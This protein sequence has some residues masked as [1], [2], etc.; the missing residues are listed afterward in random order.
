MWRPIQSKIP[1]FGFEG[2]HPSIDARM[3]RTEVRPLLNEACMLFMVALIA[4]ASSPSLSQ[5]TIP[6]TYVDNRIV[7]QCTIDGR[8]PF[9]MIVD[10]GSP[11]IVVTPEVAAKL[12]VDVREA[13][14][15]LGTGNTNA[16]LESTTIPRLTIGTL[17]FKNMPSDV[18]DL[19]EIR[20][21]LHFPRLDGVIGYPVLRKF[22]T[23]V[24]VDNQTITFARAA[25]P[26][27]PNATTTDFSGVQPEIE[28]VI[29]GI[30]GKVIVDTG[31]RSS[32]TLFGPFAR[33]YGFFGRY[34]SRKNIITG[35]GLG[36]PVYGDV[37]T[38]PSID[39]F[40]AHLT[41][42]VTRA[43]RQTGG[44]FAT[45][46]DSASIG[47]GI[48]KRFNIVYDYPNSTIIAWPSKHFA[49]PD[50]FVPPGSRGARSD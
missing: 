39:A 2:R 1:R 46:A 8:G 32:L 15:V 33:H 19:T 34:P 47:T 7:V 12:S 23:Y 25:P 40:G 24:D 41:N 45:D 5:T 28:A 18:L 9:A 27:P 26:V 17:T 42:I 35:Y 29:N 20:T 36:G 43:S 14:T 21:K 10:T 31:D 48:L 44:V 37:F 22:A 30:S 49:T 3:Q 4:A 16:N 6:F 13:G 50:V 11:T 38:L